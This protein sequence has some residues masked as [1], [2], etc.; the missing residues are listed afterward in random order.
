[1][2]FFSLFV[3]FFHSFSLKEKEKCKQCCILGSYWKLLEIRA[4]MRKGEGISLQ[5]LM[6]LI[7]QELYT[8]S[9]S[10]ESAMKYYLP[11]MKAALVFPC[12]PRKERRRKHHIK[13]L[14]NCPSNAAHQGLL[15]AWW[16]QAWA[17][18]DAL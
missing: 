9:L 8:K 3:Y 1:M 11:W 5:I 15:A 16:T 6:L 10:F 7:Q 12:P 4:N 18:I 2:L 14:V 13:T 17:E